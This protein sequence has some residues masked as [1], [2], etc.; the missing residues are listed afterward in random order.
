[1]IS[2]SFH[3][4]LHLCSLVLLSSVE[5]LNNLISELFL[6]TLSVKLLRLWSVIF[7]VKTPYIVS[8]TILVFIQFSWSVLFLRQVAMSV[9]HKNWLKLWRFWPIRGRYSVVISMGVP[10]RRF[11]SLVSVS[12]S[13]L[14]LPST[15]ILV[16]HLPITHIWHLSC[17]SV[18]K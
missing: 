15:L 5:Y 17:D 7:H 9:S 2:Y 12:N 18:A 3:C 1:M 11:I 13:A 14:P 10:G 8:K 16:Y 4:I 6:C